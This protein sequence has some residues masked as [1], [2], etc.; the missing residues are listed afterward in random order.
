[1][2]QSTPDRADGDAVVAAASPV[3]ASAAAAGE[4]LTTTLLMRHFNIANSGASTKEE[5]EEIIKAMEKED[6]THLRVFLMG[7]I[8][9][10]TDSSVLQTLATSGGLCRLLYRWIAGALKEY[11]TSS[12]FDEVFILRMLEVLSHLP[13]EYDIL[14]KHKLGKAVRAVRDAASKEGN[15]QVET[16]ANSLMDMYKEKF[17]KSNDKE[18]ENLNAQSSKPVATPTAAPSEDQSSPSTITKLDLEPRQVATVDNE[19]L[20]KLGI[21]KEKTPLRSDSTTLRTLPFGSIKRS[22]PLPENTDVD[23]ASMKRTAADNE[24]SKV[25]TTTVPQRPRKRVRFR[26][27]HDLCEVVYYE[28]DP[29]EHIPLPM[30]YKTPRPFFSRRP[31]YIDTEEARA[32]RNYVRTHPKVQYS[33][34]DFI[35]LSPQEPPEEQPTLY[36]E[37]T[38]E[39]P[40]EDLTLLSSIPSFPQ[41]QTPPSLLVVERPNY[42]GAAAAAVP[43]ANRSK[44]KGKSE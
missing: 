32:R 43:R 5:A 30:V 25:E 28:P 16:R 31:K 8:L 33:A 10:A 42:T 12:E 38:I 27:E 29:E 11:E 15:G 9:K 3:P 6:R 36:Q 14:Q 17:A 26:E 4:N 2:D 35:P 37:I 41:Q 1:M 24:P 7:L 21:Q 40:R 19:W 22:K 39:I 44:K 34:K 20:S 18:A 13:M 23:N